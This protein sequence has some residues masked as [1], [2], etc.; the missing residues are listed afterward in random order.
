MC[1]HR[2]HNRDKPKKHDDGDVEQQKWI[3]WGSRWQEIGF[4]ASAIQLF[5]A[6]VFWIATVTGIP[7]AINME[8][9]GLTDGIYWAPQVIGGTGFV[10]ARYQ[11]PGSN[12]F[13][14]RVCYL[15]WKHKVD[16]I[17]FVLFGHWDGMLDFG[18]LLGPWGSRFAALL[19][20]RARMNGQRFRVVVQHFG[21]VGLS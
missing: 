21:G 16:G 15:C 7:G 20:L 1:T 8:N 9:V 10:T 14:P 13:L 6:S 2:F 3:W 11:F 17:E 18:M 19:E 4:L 5:A 12:L